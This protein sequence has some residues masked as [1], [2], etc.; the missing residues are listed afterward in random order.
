M[1]IA[2]D[3]QTAVGALVLSLMFVRCDQGEL[4]LTTPWG[5]RPQDISDAAN[6]VERWSAAGKSRF[7][8]TFGEDNE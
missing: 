6:A 7:K 8:S 5:L 1:R 2:A 4:S 3:I